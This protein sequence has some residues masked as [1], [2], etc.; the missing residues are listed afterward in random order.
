MPFSV[1]GLSKNRENKIEPRPGAPEELHGVW[2]GTKLP[3]CVRR[4]RL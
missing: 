2:Q 1:L 4:V 3:L